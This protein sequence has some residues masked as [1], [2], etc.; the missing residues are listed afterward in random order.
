MNYVF[1][2]D[3]RRIFVTVY[4]NMSGHVMYDNTPEEGYV[5][6]VL[7]LISG[8]I[9]VIVYCLVDRL[10]VVKPGYLLLSDMVLTEVCF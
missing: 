9:C 6:Y 4:M 7:D 1:H 10:G 8:Y 2:F 5:A 3:I